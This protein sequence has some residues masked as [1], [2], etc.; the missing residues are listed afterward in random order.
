MSPNDDERR[1]EPEHDIDDRKF[2][3]GGSPR[4]WSSGIGRT[5]LCAPNAAT[6]LIPAW[7]RGKRLPNEGQRSL[8]RGH[9]PFQPRILDVVQNRLELRARRVAQRPDI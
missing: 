9:A 8:T 5:L 7:R 4:P 3:H 1:E 2:A 6:T